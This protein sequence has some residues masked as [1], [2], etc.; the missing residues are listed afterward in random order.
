MAIRPL[1]AKNKAIIQQLSLSVTL[2]TENSLIFPGNLFTEICQTSACKKT[3][4]SA[5]TFLLF[6]MRGEIVNLSTI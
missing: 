2:F 3:L 6:L 1:F 4:T 5:R